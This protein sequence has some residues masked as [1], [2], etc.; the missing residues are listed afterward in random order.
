MSA[1]YFHPQIEL[2]MGFEVTDTETMLGDVPAQYVLADYKAVD[3][4]TLPHKITI[5][6]GG[7]DYSDVQFASIAIN[8]PGAQQTFAIPEAAAKEA[9][10]AAGAGDY[11]PVAI[12]KDCRGSALRSCLLA[13]QHDRGVPEVAGARRSAVHRDSK[14]DAGARPS[15]SSF[16]A[17]RSS[18]RLSRIIT[19]ITRAACEAL[20]R[21]A[22][23]SWSRRGMSLHCARSWRRRIRTLRTSWPSRRA[24]QQ[25]TG[26]I[27]VYEG[28]KVIA[29]G[30]QSLE[31]HAITG[32]PH[33]EP[34][35]VA[36]VPMPGALFQSDLFFPGTGGNFSP[37]AQHLLESVRK[38][39]LR[40]TTNVGGHGGVGPFAEL[41]KAG[42]PP[43]AKTN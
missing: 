40:V 41:V 37:A 21:S 29:D 38:L 9:E 3:G 35:V 33:V 22:Q 16:P 18:T 8:D 34:M 30:G 26:S 39:G 19:T 15:R 20:P 23:R 27:E 11:S 42:T 36:F 17:S 43:A 1:L 25:P 4:I 13:Q 12:T 5:R 7:Q 6:K 31:L 24:A 28:K 10:E 14:Q 2:L 32:S